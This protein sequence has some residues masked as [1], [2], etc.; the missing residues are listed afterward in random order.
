MK[1]GDTLSKIAQNYNKGI[2]GE[3]VPTTNKPGTIGQHIN[4][5]G[6]NKPQQDKKVA[7][8]GTQDPQNWWQSMLQKEKIFLMMNS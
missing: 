4:W 5:G 7:T 2:I 6:K 8:R 3:N 1:S